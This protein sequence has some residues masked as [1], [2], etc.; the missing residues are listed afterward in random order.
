ME[1]SRE[2]SRSPRRL[3]PCSDLSV[4]QKTRM[5][6][7]WDTHH[8]STSKFQIGSEYAVR[9]THTSYFERNHMLY[10]S[11]RWTL[12][13]SSAATRFCDVALRERIKVQPIP[14]SLDADIPGFL[15]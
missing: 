10:C 9:K 7:I 6:H 8:T 15:G 13:A 5:F 1:A 3:P 12:T 11:F 14:G 2:F 4:L